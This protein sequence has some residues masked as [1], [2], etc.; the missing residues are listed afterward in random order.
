LFTA[1][2]FAV[3]FTQPVGRGLVLLPA[4]AFAREPIKPKPA[5]RALNL[6]KLMTGAGG[7]GKYADVMKPKQLPLRLGTLQKARA[8]ALSRLIEIPYCDLNASKQAVFFGGERRVR[9]ALSV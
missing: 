6:A 3:R 7:L 2:V 8:A 9:S 5:R 1:P 4:I